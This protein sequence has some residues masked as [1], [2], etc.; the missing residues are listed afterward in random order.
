MVNGSN[1]RSV[2]ALPGVSAGSDVGAVFEGAVVDGVVVLGDV[3]AVVD[4]E[5]D[6]LVAALNRSP[7]SIL[8][9]P[10]ASVGE[11]AFPATSFAAAANHRAT[12][13][14]CPPDP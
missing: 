10:D 3:G 7:V 12:S 14:A 4:D 1:S 9:F 8:M 13:A 2:S 5:I 6:E 11:N